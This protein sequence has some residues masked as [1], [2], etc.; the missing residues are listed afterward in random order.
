V[1]DSTRTRYRRRHSPA[2]P[3]PAAPTDAGNAADVRASRLP[4][5]QYHT[6]PS[7]D[8]PTTSPSE[9]DRTSR[10]RLG[11]QIR[12]ARVLADLLA[13]ALRD[14]L[15][16]IAWTVGDVGA[17]L[18]G[19]CYGRIGADRRRQFQA[20][21][22]AVGATPKPELTG[23]G[24]VTYLRRSPPGTTRWSTS[25]CWPTFIPTRPRWGDA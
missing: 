24:G 6:D 10:E 1:Y 9:D 20:W 21:C 3:T 5:G 19:R 15:P 22:T 14:G 23:F 8:A 18:A 12:A 2:S 16:R 25:S 7:F 11:W 17:N 4:A 13:L